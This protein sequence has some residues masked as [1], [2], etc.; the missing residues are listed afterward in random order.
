MLKQL[1]LSLNGQCTH[2]AAPVANTT[3]REIK[4][5]AEHVR[6]ASLKDRLLLEGPTHR[7][8]GAWAQRPK[9]L[10]LPYNKE[11]KSPAQQQI[12]SSPLSCHISYQRCEDTRGRECHAFPVSPP[13][14]T[15]PMAVLSVCLGA[16]CQVLLHAGH[17]SKEKPLYTAISWQQH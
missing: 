3:R 5:N 15:I 4:R 10:Q 8:T 12:Q 17:A 6:V 1:N 14:G 13:G 9:H 16:L 2:G 7:V 11:V